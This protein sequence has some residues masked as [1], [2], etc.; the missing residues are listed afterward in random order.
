[1]SEKTVRI[2]GASAFW[3][4]SSVA[5]PQL[6]RRANV[7]YIM[8]DYLAEVTL[9]IMVA[10]KRKDPALGYATDFV[11]V[12]MRQVLREVKQKGIKIIANAGG[13]NPRACVTALETLA[14]ELNVAVRVACVEGD[15]L[16][17]NLDALRA[18]G[19]KEMASGAPLPEK[20]TSANAYLGAFPIARA[21]QD[22]ADIVVT[23]RVADSAMALGVLIHEFGWT[24]QD[25]DRL[26]SGTL[27][28]H[29]LE[30]GAQATGGL[31]TDWQSVPDWADIG[32]PIAEC[33]ADGS[34]VVSKPEGTGGS[35][36]PAIIAEQMLY[37]IGDPGAYVVPD[38]VA[39]FRRVT[40]RAVGKDRVEVT[41]AKG[42]AP[43]PTYK[44]SATYLDGYRCTGTLTIIGIDAAKKAQRTAEAILE[45]TRA[46]FRG[47]NVGDYAETHIEILGAEAQYGPYSRTQDAREVVMK[48]SVRHK[49]Q[50]ALDVFSREIS[51]A[52]TSWSPG[53]TGNFGG[54]RPT[55]SPV[56]RLFSFLIDKGAVTPRVRIGDRE[57]VLQQPQGSIDKGPAPILVA[58]A[59][60]PAP[61]ALTRRARLIE[62]AYARSGDK[63]DIANIGVIARRAEDLP[64]LR[65]E[66]TPQRVKAYFAHLVTGEVRRYDLPGSCA[67][68]FMLEGAL[69]GGGA[70]SLRNDPLAKGFA[71]MLLDMEIDAPSAFE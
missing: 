32:Y 56:I 7:D 69:G 13:V 66:L 19:V 68:N 9:S 53:T 1:M 44:V 47:R 28:G 49:D 12:Q 63:G 67:M 30:C 21:L 22:G 16:M 70:G 20:V 6:V 37:E 38:V 10:A 64:W 24:A 18:S 51:P 43:T 5:A 59:A 52:G 33:R 55:P 15:D 26:A 40:M 35:V 54:G 34:F 4:D 58:A 36:T 42:R 29:I 8:F 41:G 71:Q 14:R 31:H 60:A 11:S 50:R 61:H 57:S 25:H 48:L 23:G 65:R 27:C 3:G 39:D 17:G 2:A 45:R 62:F 46:L